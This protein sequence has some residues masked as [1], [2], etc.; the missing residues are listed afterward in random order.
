MFDVFGT[1]PGGATHGVGVTG[2]P[3]AFI[4]DWLL[5]DVALL[6]VIVAPEFTAVP[7]P[8]EPV[9][10]EVIGPVLLVG[11]GTVP[12]GHGELTFDLVVVVPFVPGVATAPAG[13]FEFGFVVDVAE[14]GVF[15]M[16]LVVPFCCVAEVAEPGAAL[17]FGLIPWL[18]VMP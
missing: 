5:V 17:G 1:V 10:D 4:A 12:A 18:G 6:V 11:A 2:A 14:A 13:T 8:V 9:V 3:P 7:L 16:V 15:P